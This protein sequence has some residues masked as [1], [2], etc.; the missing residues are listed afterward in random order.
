[1]GLSIARSIVEMHRGQLWV[2][3]GGGRGC[4]FAFT[5]PTA[6]DEAMTPRR[7]HEYKEL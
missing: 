2:E 1:M 3:P 7:D 5:L 4:T 6:P